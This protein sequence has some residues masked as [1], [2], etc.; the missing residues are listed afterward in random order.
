MLS[1][2]LRLDL[3]AFAASLLLM[4]GVAASHAPEVSQSS[5]VTIT[6]GRLCTVTPCSFAELSDVIDGSQD[7]DII[8]F[9][10][11]AV[12]GELLPVSRTITFASTK[13]ISKRITIDPHYCT[14]FGCLNILNFP[15]ITFSGASARSQFLVAVAGGRLTLRNLSVV[16]GVSASGGGCIAA[17][18][19]VT[20]QNVYFGGCRSTGGRGGAIDIGGS[21]TLLIANTI[22][23]NNQT[24][25]GGGAIWSS[26]PVSIVGSRFEQNS[27]QGMGAS[28]GGGAIYYTGPSLTISN[29]LFLSN[30][31]SLGGCLKTNSAVLVSVTL[32]ACSASGDG[33]AIMGDSLD[34]DRSLF[35]NNNASG[36]GGAVDAKNATIRSGRFERNTVYPKTISSGVPGV[37]D[38]SY[39]YGGAI[40]TSNN[41]DVSGTQ[42][43]SNTVSGLA[44]GFFIG[45]GGAVYGNARTTVRDALFSGNRAEN[46]A[47]GGAL[48][49]SGTAQ[50][51]NTQIENN[52]SDSGGGISH[53]GGPLTVTLGTLTHNIAIDGGAIALVA[54]ARAWLSGTAII[55]NTGILG[56]GIW[57]DVA[58]DA[59]LSHVTVLDN[60]ATHGGGVH[61]K[62]RLTVTHSELRANRAISEG[63]GLWLG[64]PAQV[65]T[66]TLVNNV[67]QD[68]GGAFVFNNSS[69][70]RHST[71]QANTAA[72]NGGGVA[73]GPF[74][75]I[76]LN[77]S[78][79]LANS[80]VTGGGLHCFFA[81]MV[82]ATSILSN[83][84]SV[85]GG[86]ISSR[87]PLLLENV[88]LSGNRATFDGG[89]VYLPETIGYLEA[90]NSTIVNNSANA[91]AVYENPLSTNPNSKFVNSVLASNPGD[92]CKG[93]AIAATNSLSSDGSCA[94]AGAGNKNSTP[95]GLGQ[96]QSS[97]GWL[98]VHVPVSSS[99]L[100]NAGDLATCLAKDQRGVARP[101]G[102]QCD[103]GAVEWVTG[104]PLG[105]KAVHLPMLTR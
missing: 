81:C 64:A 45:G 60:A 46:G 68:G 48:N 57:Q 17:G 88:T 51:S 28:Q 29:T 66:S 84:A 14:G 42:F 82:S 10:C 95:A 62:G 3:R 18:G 20:V 7:G 91:G 34:I 33:G 104:D 43:V 72:R 25:G 73:G 50:L 94:F 92:N 87:A 65:L 69:T 11:A 37:P 70:F 103:I 79:L 90:R 31:A 58:T 8:K 49:T 97:L 40:A 52:H 86:G 5:C 35:V 99:P 85:Y 16:N 4:P 83:T 27:E 6:G 30:T 12:V 55:S 47:R 75:T 15:I 67:A 9:D 24:H 71:L 1:S 53:R 21:G 102:L 93:K 59:T 74:S 77:D 26:G 80:A 63:G 36:Y 61:A 78:L 105:R 13:T 101:Q 98:P 23:L 100:V 96:L 41:L 89:A 2:V 22:F 54:A 76:N 38:T 44:G 19:S 56:G 39:A 32:Q